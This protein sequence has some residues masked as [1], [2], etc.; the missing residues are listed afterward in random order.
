MSKCKCCHKVL[1]ISPTPVNGLPTTNL[2]H[3]QPYRR[4][5]R[6]QN[7]KIAIRLEG[8]LRVAM[9]TD[10]EG[11]ILLRI[12]SNSSCLLSPKSRRPPSL[13]PI[14]PSTVQRV[15]WGGRANLS[16][17]FPITGKR[18]MGPLPLLQQPRVP[19]SSVI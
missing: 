10:R 13:T 2:Y 9:E 1:I 4:L 16:Q 12:R 3:Q 14:T 18:L 19:S 5:Y 7:D 11:M 17:P 15:H 6:P 8:Q